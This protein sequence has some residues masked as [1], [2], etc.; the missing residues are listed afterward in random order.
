MA[1]TMLTTNALYTLMGK[2]VFIKNMKPSYIYMLFQIAQ[3]PNSKEA[4]DMYELLQEEQLRLK[5]IDTEFNKITRKVMADYENDLLSL[6]KIKTGKEAIAL[7]SEKKVAEKL[8]KKL[9]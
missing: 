3:N 7:K 1:T 6:K 4:Q 2:S 5:K 8:L 9:K